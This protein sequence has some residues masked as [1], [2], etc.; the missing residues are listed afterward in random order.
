MDK[1]RCYYCAVSSREAKL[2]T[3]VEL[4]LALAS[5]SQAKLAL[6]IACR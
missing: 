6:A 1:L 2:A 4:L 5:S 3:L